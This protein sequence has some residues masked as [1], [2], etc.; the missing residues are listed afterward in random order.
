MSSP[1]VRGPGV[2]E[3]IL[4]SPDS[5]AL[6][7]EVSDLGAP[8]ISVWLVGAE[9]SVAK[10]ASLHQPAG[11][12]ISPRTDPELDAIFGPSGWALANPRFEGATLVADIVCRGTAERCGQLPAYQ[13]RGGEDG[14]F[15]TVVQ[16]S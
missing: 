1:S 16:L 14:V 8:W 2:P 3:T 9:V 10:P 15:D 4:W 6:V 7:L 5:S 13:A 11:G 12:N